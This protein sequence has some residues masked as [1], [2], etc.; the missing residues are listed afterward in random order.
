[1]PPQAYCAR[2]LGYKL[3]NADFLNLR[4]NNDVHQFRMEEKIVHVPSFKKIKMH[5]LKVFI[6]LFHIALMFVSMTN[7]NNN[8]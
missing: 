6:I 1:M 8:K 7:K 4:S 2:P 3:T 5:T